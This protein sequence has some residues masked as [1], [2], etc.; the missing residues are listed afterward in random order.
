MRKVLIASVGAL[1]VLFLATPGFPDQGTAAVQASGDITLKFG[2]MHE[3]EFEVRDNYDLDNGLTDGCARAVTTG[4]DCSGAGIGREVSRDG[5]IEQE[6][7]LIIEGSQ[8][9][10]W[11]ARI[12]LDSEED[13]EAERFV[14]GIERAWADIKLYDTPVHVRAGLLGP[15][16]LD[17]FSLVWYGDEKTGVKVY[18]THGNISWS[19]W[20]IKEDETSNDGGTTSGRDGDQ[21]YY[22][23][24][25]DLDFGAFQV[26]PAIGYVRNR[27]TIDD[28]RFATG[29]ASID[30]FG[31]DFHNFRTA[32][33]TADGSNTG[34]GVTVD[35][36][37]VYPGVIAKGTF[38]P[39][40]FV[41]EVFGAFGEIGDDSAVD[42]Q[43]NQDVAAYLVAVDVGVKLG[44]WTPHA[45]IIW[46]S[47]DDNP[48]DDDA[49]AWAP[50]ESDNDN[51]LGMRGIVMD[52]DLDVIGISEDAITAENVAPAARQYFTQP[53]L[54]ALF[55]GLKG[56]PTKKIVTDM[57]VVYFQWDMEKQ[58]E[59]VNGMVTTTTCN[60]GGSPTQTSSQQGVCANSN[61]TNA[62]ADGSGLISTV[63]D[64]LGWEINGA[65][66]Y[67]YNKHV[68][69]T[70]SAAVFFPGD[71]AEVVAQCANHA[72]GGYLLSGD[73]QNG[74]SDGADPQGIEISTVAGIARAD[75]EAFNTEVELNVEF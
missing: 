46:A 47:G 33:S 13:W 25:V 31:S 27:N 8:G 29:L 42:A 45:G 51:L 17:P 63:D 16:G 36:S 19:I 35:E 5:F 4:N 43:R 62:V 20:Y 67:S 26:S 18:A 73:A 49:E 54:I 24:R 57:N 28:S 53:G 7:R 52:D 69:L 6:T 55:V 37:V 11:K 1:L 75:D 60:N 32:S 72:G 2:L 39:V 44:A 38:G 30:T 3:I 48:H 41:G 56:R 61:F 66:T 23:A 15:D 22:M 65:V 14:V 74:C 64:E 12:A 34:G 10:V 71:G 9:D 58:W 59:Y 68:T 40:S 50:I 70:L 21:D